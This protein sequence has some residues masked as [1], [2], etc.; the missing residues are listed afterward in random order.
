MVL[1]RDGSVWLSTGPDGLG[2]DDWLVLDSDGRPIGR[3]KL[4]VGLDVL[5]IDPPH[6]WASETDELDVPYL[7]RFRIE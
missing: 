7:V 3:V 2:H 1:A 5:V 4:P 6:L